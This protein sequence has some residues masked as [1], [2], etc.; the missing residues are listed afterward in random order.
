MEAQR[1]FESENNIKYFE[2]RKAC[3]ATGCWLTCRG[4]FVLSTH[5]DNIFFFFHIWD[6]DGLRNAEMIDF[7]YRYMNGVQIS[8]NIDKFQNS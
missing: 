7:F 8:R 3:S 2:I 6:T 4:A 1:K 5:S